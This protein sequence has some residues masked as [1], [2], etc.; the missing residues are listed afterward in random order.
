M[1]EQSLSEILRANGYKTVE[2]RDA[3]LAAIAAQSDGSSEVLCSGYRVFPDGTKCKGCRD[4]MMPPAA[5]KHAASVSSPTPTT[6][7]SVE[8]FY[9]QKCSTDFMAA[10]QELSSANASL[11]SRLEE[12]E[13]NLVIEKGLTRIY[14]NDIQ[15]LRS[16]LAVAEADRERLD[17]LEN[18]WR[19]FVDAWKR[20]PTSDAL[21][22][23]IDSAMTKEV[24]GKK[25]P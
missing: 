11:T 7:V 10:N 16:S 14:A 4:C 15:N 25:E 24:S 8:E 17:W 12:A 23:A 9:R 2:G 20:Q 22:E 18:Q 5:A 19:D 13:K 21:R 6:S 3:V 1:S